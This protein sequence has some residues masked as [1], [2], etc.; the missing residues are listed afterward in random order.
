MSPSIP[1]VPNVLFRCWDCCKC[2]GEQRL[3]LQGRGEGVPDSA[4]VMIL[5]LWAP[6]GSYF[7]GVGSR[8]PLASPP[9]QAS[10]AAHFVRP[11]HSACE[12]RKSFACTKRGCRP[13]RTCQKPAPNEV[14][15]PGMLAEPQSCGAVRH[16]FLSHFWE[17]PF[18]TKHCHFSIYSYLHFSVSH[19]EMV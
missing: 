3:E 2:Y 4:T 17:T 1:A 11:K 18:S 13:P 7:I 5:A 6:W 12:K 10:P 15:T 16:P 8:W 19:V 9:L 14:R